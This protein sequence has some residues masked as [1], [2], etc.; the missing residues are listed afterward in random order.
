[1]PRRTDALPD[2]A[3]ALLVPALLALAGC[4]VGPDYTP[5]PGR[6]PDAFT[7]QADDGFAVF[8][9]VDAGAPDPAWW[10]RLGDPT[11][12]A[13]VARAAEGNL[14]VR[15]AVARITEAR[16]SLGVSESE[17]LP[18]LDASG[19]YSRNRDSASSRQGQFGGGG[20][21]Y[22]SFRAGFDA[23]WELDLF[24]R[25]RRSVEA[26]E[27]SLQAAQEDRR[28]VLVTLVSDVARNYVELRGF[29]RRLEIAR[30]NLALQQ[31]TL[32][33]TRARFNAGLTT[34]LDVAQAEA[35]L[36][37]TAA[38]VP[39]F[40]ASAQRAI[41]RL[42]VLLGQNPAALRSELSSG[43]SIPAVP[44][45]VPVG[46]P[47][48]LLRRRPD[49]RRA[50]RNIVAANALIGVAVADLYPRFSLTGSFGL[51]SDRFAD[52][53]DAT[54][55]FW[56]VGPAVRW[57]ILDWNR[58][59]SNINVQQARAEQTV[60]VYEQT[61]LNG[62][63]ETENALVNYAR[64]QSRRKSL[65]DAVASSRRAFDLANQLYTSGVSDFQRVIDSQRALVSAE[66]QLVNSD[67]IVTTN[68]IALYKAIGGGW[69]GVDGVTY[70]AVD[71]AIPRPGDPA[72]RPLPAI[73][74]HLTGGGGAGGSVQAADTPGRA[75]DGPVVP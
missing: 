15:L 18:T 4:T 74:S 51:A 14:D 16:A 17:G 35:A 43:G 58:V 6:A 70:R 40:D 59:R 8:S 5:P 48:E 37:E 67:T 3:G 29:Q 62:L 69:E 38:L 49:I 11:L 46:L 7:H 31:E 9:R 19:S 22:D 45:V 25:V 32:N 63:E 60:I 30:K 39:E 28:D 41:N 27:A 12:D 33:L 56:T 52:W 36:A 20:E 23:S 24:G 50:E 61:V 1:M 21:N 64:E 13:L 26:A 55:R 68:L 47:S 73:S 65:A 10:S 44:E 71:E 53:A 57:P 42:S 75:G 72:N 34:D 66:D 2:L 54:S